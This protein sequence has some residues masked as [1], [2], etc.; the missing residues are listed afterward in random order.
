MEGSP[1]GHYRRSYS[2]AAAPDP[3]PRSRGGSIGDAVRASVYAGSSIHI[4]LRP[5]YGL[6]CPDKRG[7]AG[8]EAKLKGQAS[9][10]R[11]VNL[12]L[13]LFPQC[14]YKVTKI[15]RVIA[16]ASA[17]C[18]FDHR[19]RVPRQVSQ[20]RYLRRAGNG[21]GGLLREHDRFVDR[22]LR[23]LNVLQTDIVHD[24]GNARIGGAPR[25]DD[26]NAVGCGRVESRSRVDVL[27]AEDRAIYDLRSRAFQIEEPGAGHELIELVLRHACPR[28]GRRARCRRH[29]IG[30]GPGICHHAEITMGVDHREVAYPRRYGLGARGLRSVQPVADS[31]RVPQR[32]VQR[33]VL[34]AGSHISGI[35]V[36]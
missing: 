4:L 25:V 2:L 16:T 27:R 31:C 23:G 26:Q 22:V 18:K 36:V 11:R 15:C 6:V 13:S 35:A 5:S 19:Y 28:Q 34:A 21:H 1:L 33:I 17:P 24:D 12:T 9:T 8:V 7:A 20:H 30:T 29:A 3:A 14:T 32:T 10:L